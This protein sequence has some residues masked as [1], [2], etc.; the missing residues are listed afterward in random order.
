[1]KGKW[2]LLIDLILFIYLFSLISIFN[3]FI[4]YLQS[5][6]FCEIFSVLFCVI[7]LKITTI[8]CRTLKHT[9]LNR[10]AYNAKQGSKRYQ[11]REYAVPNKGT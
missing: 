5:H 8:W 11:T 1:M 6:I 4:Y 10:G 7:A 9:V 3:F 2:V